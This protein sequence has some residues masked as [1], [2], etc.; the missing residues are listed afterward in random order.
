ME[1]KGR[2]FFFLQIATNANYTTFYYFAILITESAFWDFARNWKCS[3]NHHVVNNLIFAQKKL[4]KIS[5][6]FK[7]PCKKNNSLTSRS[8]LNLESN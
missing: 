1:S 8:D 7:L 2:L 3:K 4:N 6:T 5:V